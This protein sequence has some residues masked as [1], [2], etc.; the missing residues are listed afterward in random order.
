MRMSV[1]AAGGAAAAGS[2]KGVLA[3]RVGTRSFLIAAEGANRRPVWHRRRQWRRQVP[4]IQI[5]M[6]RF[7]ANERQHR[8]DV[9]DRLARDREIIVGEDGEV[10]ELAGFDLTLL[11]DLGGEPGVGLGPEP[12]RGFAIELVARRVELRPT[13]GAA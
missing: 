1:H 6:D 12:Q 3:L 9:L 8:G 13:D 5:A 10:R 2:R 7:A 11:A 4:E